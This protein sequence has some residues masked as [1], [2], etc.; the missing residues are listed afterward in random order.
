M[1]EEASA[2]RNWN[3]VLFKAIKICVIVV[4]VFAIESARVSHLLEKT[5]LEGGY[6]AG[7]VQRGGEDYK[8]LTLFVSLP[9]ATCVLFIDSIQKEDMQSEDLRNSVRVLSVSTSDFCIAAKV[10]ALYCTPFPP[11]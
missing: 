9:P 4:R 8:I 10:H 7:D 1:L 5:F 3:S 6:N 11:L 2:M